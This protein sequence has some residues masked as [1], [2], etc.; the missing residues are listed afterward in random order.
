MSI[1]SITVPYFESGMRY[2]GHKT[3]LNRYAI[4]YDI[5]IKYIDSNKVFW[6][7]DGGHA[8][9]LIN[10]KPFV[11]NWSDHDWFLSKCK[12]INKD[13]EIKYYYSK[14]RTFTGAIAIGR[15][16]CI[17]PS[18]T[19]LDFKRDEDYK[20]YFKMSEEGG[21]YTCNSDRILHKQNLGTVSRRIKVRKILTD[22]YGDNVDG[23]VKA[24]DKF[25]FF[26]H[27]RNCL[28]SVCVPGANNDML[29]RGHWEMMGLG[30]C[31]VSPPINTIVCWD[32]PLVD[33]VNY[34]ACKPDYSN[35][36]ETIEWC[37][38]NRDKCREIGEN[39]RIFFQ[40]AY[41]PKNYWKWIEYILNQHN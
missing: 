3:F 26:E 9:I 2:Y 22:T 17:Y 10:D 41:L 34:V 37:R 38:E 24:G 15:E 39:A 32:E 40:K 18:G 4:L 16:N 20:K 19:I 27:A 31:I 35:L 7:S 6:C 36:I 13:P 12:Y 8:H 11:V 30:V 29:D 5:D 21:I 14:L 23:S 1:K 28:V 33:G 25:W